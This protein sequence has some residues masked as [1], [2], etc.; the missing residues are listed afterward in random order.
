MKH[1]GNY[2]AVDPAYSRHMECE[3]C[4]VSWTGCWDNFQC[5]QCGQGESPG[6]LLEGQSRIELL[7]KAVL[8]L[9]EC[10][11]FYANGDT[12]FWLEKETDTHCAE[13][14]GKRARETLI[15]VEK[16]L[17]EKE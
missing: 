8:R 13:E 5:P 6:N 2:S 9:K 4:N 17:K 15:E 10:V 11:E 14:N 12:F 3:K 1:L 7:E 16:A